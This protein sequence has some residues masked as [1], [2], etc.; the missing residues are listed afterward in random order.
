MAERLDELTGRHLTTIHIIGGGAQNA[1]LNR[2]TADATGRRVVVGP[3]E[4]TALGNVLVQALSAGHLA[5]LAG[6]RALVRRSFPLETFDPSPSPAWQTAYQR[7]LELK[8][9]RSI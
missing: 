3:V 2:F 8:T 9:S 5:S 1:L 4:A 7:Y 6:A